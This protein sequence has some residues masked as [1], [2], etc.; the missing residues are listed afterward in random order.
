MICLT[1]RLHSVERRFA[2]GQ[3]AAREIAAFAR[4]C[5]TSGSTLSLGAV[6]CRLWLKPGKGLF[7]EPRNKCNMPPPGGKSIA[8]HWRNTNH[9]ENEE[10]S[11]DKRAEQLNVILTA[12]CACGVIVV[13]RQASNHPSG[14]VR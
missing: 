9:S 1:A 13:C 11:A 5:L 14:E 3:N 6:R 8:L 4:W 2:E 7:E 12:R 10:D